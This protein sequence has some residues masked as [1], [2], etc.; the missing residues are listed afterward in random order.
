MS[1]DKYLSIFW[2]QLEVIVF[3]ILQI[4]LATW[5]VFKIGEYHSD[6]PQF[7]LGNIQSHDMLRPIVHE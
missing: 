4:F 3:I 5:A 6:I 7:K 2:Y 1:T